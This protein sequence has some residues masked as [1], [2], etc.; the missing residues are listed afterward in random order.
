MPRGSTGPT[1]GPAQCPTALIPAPQVRFQAHRGQRTYRSTW[2]AYRGIAAEEGAAGFAKGL[3]PSVGRA[4]VINGCG[5]ASY[6]ATKVLT[7]R[8]TGHSQGLVPQVVGSLVSGLVSALVS[9]PCA[10]ARGAFRAVLCCG[11]LAERPTHVPSAYV[12]APQPSF[13]LFFRPEPFQSM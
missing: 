8:I 11:G 10:Y 1:Q 2:A 6:D 7:A 12:F 5:I 13:S 4:A 3:A 9:T